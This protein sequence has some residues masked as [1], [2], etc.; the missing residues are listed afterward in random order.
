[1]S[2][3]L[4]S[5]SLRICQQRAEI[6]GGSQ[7]ERERD[8]ERTMRQERPFLIKSELDRIRPVDAPSHSLLDRVFLAAGVLLGREHVYIE[9]RHPR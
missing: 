4:S 7:E 8:F 1:M 3:Q 6:P 2:R 9:R 5:A